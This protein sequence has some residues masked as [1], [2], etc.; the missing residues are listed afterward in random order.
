MNDADVR[1]QIFADKL[2]GLPLWDAGRAANLIWFEFG[3]RKT[4]TKH[5]RNEQQV[6]GEWALHVQCAWRLTGPSGIEVAYQDIYYP[7]SSEGKVDLGEFDWDRQGKNRCDEKLAKIWATDNQGRFTVTNA[8]VGRNG[9]LTLELTDGWLLEVFPHSSGPQEAWR[10]FQ[11][12][13]ET[14]EM[15]FCGQGYEKWLPEPLNPT[16]P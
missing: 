14:E 16:T 9:F 13:A 10:L 1:A 3:A 7:A 12:Y 8:V 4:V 11:P 15:I 5:T 2:R 6:V